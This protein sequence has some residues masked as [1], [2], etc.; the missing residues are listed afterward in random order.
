MIDRYC[1]P[2]MS[3]VWSREAKVQRWLD[4]EIAICEGWVR[5]G[6]VPASDLAAI[7][8]RAKFDVARCDEIEK[9]TRHDLMAFVRNVSEN[10]SGVDALSPESEQKEND[11]SRWI[12]FGVTSYDVIDTALAMLMRDGCGVLLDSIK[13][14]QDTISSLFERHGS[15][16]CI[17][18][19]HGIHA[20]PVTFGHKLQGWWQELGRSADRIRAAQKD[21]SVGKVS[22]AVGIH[23]HVSPE[24]ERSV[25]ESLGLRPDP[26][27]TQIVARDRHANLLCTLAVLAGSCERIATE[28]RNLQR[29]EILEVQEEF[30]AGQTGSSAMPHKR[31]PWNSETVCGLARIVR[32]NAH[33]ML[34]SVMTWHE[35]DLTNSS[36][37]RIVFPDTFQLADFIVQRL[38][39]I[40]AGL[41]VMPENMARNL[42]QMGDLVFS[43]HVMVALIQS[44]LSREGAYKV[45]QRNAAKAWEGEDFKES[46]K[47]DPVVAARLGAVEVEEVFSL[48]HHL[49]NAPQSV[50]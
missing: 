34:E 16:P 39:R 21:V 32:G 18:R 50:E 29:T 37:E 30:A 47:R 31:N 14:L 43:E 41:V 7:R 26:N 4:V 42:S 11:P 40:L 38:A 24:M 20:E 48:E 28:L 49:R 25:C 36:L 2:A 27:S 12:H 23:A 46:V 45:A 8:A 35:R 15:V 6:V 9:V 44:G 17:G 13:S 5:E 33:A 1:T 22:G 19:T 3:A 10:V